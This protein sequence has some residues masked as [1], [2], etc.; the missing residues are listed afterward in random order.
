MNCPN[1]L[2][3]MERQDDF[4]YN[5]FNLARG[6]RPLLKQPAASYICN[7]CGNE[8]RWIKDRPLIKFFDA[9]IGRYANDID[10]NFTQEEEEK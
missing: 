1:C 3:V 2:A 4:E 5:N 7:N 9:A 8:Y 6:S 10:W